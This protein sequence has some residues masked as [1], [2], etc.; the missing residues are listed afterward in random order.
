MDELEGCFTALLPFHAVNHFRGMRHQVRHPILVVVLS[1]VTM[2]TCRSWQVPLL[3]SRSLQYNAPYA[4]RI[5]PVVGM[6]HTTRIFM[7]AKASSGLFILDAVSMVSVP[8][9]RF[10]AQPLFTP[11]DPCLQGLK[12]AWRG[13]VFAAALLMLRTLATIAIK[14]RRRTPPVGHA[15]AVD[16][17]ADV[18]TKDM[19]TELKGGNSEAAET[20]ATMQ[21]EAGVVED[22]E[23]ITAAET[24]AAAA[25][26][27]A[28]V[29][30]PAEAE[31]AAT[32][33]DTTAAEAEAAAAEAEAAAAGAVAAAAAQAQVAAAQAHAAA[34]AEAEA[35]VVAAESKAAAAIAATRASEA[36]AAL[37]AAAE[38]LAAQALAAATEA[39]VLIKR[40]VI[41]QTSTLDNGR[42]DS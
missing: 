28:N 9:V 33:A 20:A 14:G 24:E 7:P 16:G 41:E 11:L 34:A 30:A 18:L 21:A 36:A 37:D 40:L 8:C 6:R 39:E 19:A 31:A 38:R 22:M 27:W 26:A 29:A 13:A 35:A 3:T 25:T 12:I 23:A 42:D 32:D 17:S 1:L 15:A 5:S 4:A 2:R 10:T